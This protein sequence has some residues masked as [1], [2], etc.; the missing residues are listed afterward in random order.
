[1]V[2]SSLFTNNLEIWYSLIALI[3]LDTCMYQAHVCSIDFLSNFLKLAS[4][5]HV[6]SII[7]RTHK[8]NAPALNIFVS[9]FSTSCHTRVL[10]QA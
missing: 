6:Y 9:K 5:L 2:R 1:M 10:S 8:N 7:M 4:C 3:Y